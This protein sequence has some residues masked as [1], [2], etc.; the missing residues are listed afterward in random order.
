MCCT[1]DRAWIAAIRC[2]IREVHGSSASMV[3]MHRWWCAS[4]K[5]NPSPVHASI[6]HQSPTY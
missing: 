5:G 3:H 2:C 1:G 4:T 6:F